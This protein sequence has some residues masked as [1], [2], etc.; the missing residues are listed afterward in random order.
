MANLKGNSA[1]ICLQAKEPVATAGL[2]LAREQSLTV[3]LLILLTIANT[4]PTTTTVLDSLPASPPLHTQTYLLPYPPA[5]TF[6]L[7]I[8]AA[9]LTPS[10]WV[11]QP[12]PLYD[13]SPIVVLNLQQIHFAAF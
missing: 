9:P 8:V 13:C 1:A 12:S 4:P 7:P 6:R 5:N 3:R 11:R 2:R 10:P